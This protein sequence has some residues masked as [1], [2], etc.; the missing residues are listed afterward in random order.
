[1]AASAR[2]HLQAA[3]AAATAEAKLRA[4][5]AAWRAKPAAELAKAIVALGDELDRARPRLSGG[6]RPG[7]L[8]DKSQRMREWLQ[9][10]KNHDDV[11]TGWLLRNSFIGDLFRFQDPHTERLPR[12]KPDP[13]LTDAVLAQLQPGGYITIRSWMKY[14]RVLEKSNDARAIA[15]L[16]AWLDKRPPK[17]KQTRPA[18]EVLAALRAAFPDGPPR[19]DDREAQLL[20]VARPKASVDETELLAA[21]WAAP[22]DDGPR[23]VYAD[24][25]Q[26]RGDPR[27]EFITLGCKKKPNA[28]DNKRMRTLQKAHGD[29]WLGPLQPAVLLRKTV[30]F[31]RGFL[32]L[33]SVPVMLGLGPNDRDAPG[34]QRMAALFDHKAW[35]T[36]RE[37]RMQKLGAKTRAP[38]IA[39]LRRLGVKVVL[40]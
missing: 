2:D 12:W 16:E 21:V 30:S 29:A 34:E 5:V 36:L 27:G 23:L 11:L 1:M 35:S 18:R 25:L 37:V 40:K 17:D 8:G 13:R 31:E 22:D 26:E 3:A 6:A 24:Y 9:L 4:L 38:L 20:A 19:L 33:C 39:H 14:W 7:S 28:A 32:S 10:E 15:P